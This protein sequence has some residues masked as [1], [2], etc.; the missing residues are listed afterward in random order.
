MDVVT[1]LAGVFSV[2]LK[3]ASPLV[4]VGAGRIAEGSPEWAAVDKAIAA[5]EAAQAKKTAAPAAAASAGAAPAAKKG[6]EKAAAPAKPAKAAK[7]TA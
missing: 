2:R 7:A 1:K 4:I 3:P 5:A 6:A